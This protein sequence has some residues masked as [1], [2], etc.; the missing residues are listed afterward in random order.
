MFYTPEIDNLWQ[1]LSTQ[2]P[3]I[4]LP[5]HAMTH[6]RRLA[7]AISNYQIISMMNSEIISKI[8]ANIQEANG[9]KVAEAEHQMQNVPFSMPYYTGHNNGS[10]YL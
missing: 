8:E 3:Y 1:I 7:S 5:L 10:S 6:V 9:H 4:N 2:R